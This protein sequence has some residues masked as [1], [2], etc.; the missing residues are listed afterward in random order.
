MVRVFPM[1]P[2]VQCFA[3]LVA[4]VK[5]VACCVTVASLQETSVVVVELIGR[6]CSFRLLFVVFSVPVLVPSA[7]FLFQT[8][9]LKT[10]LPLINFCKLSSLAHLRS[11][12]SR[13]SWSPWLSFVFLQQSSFRYRP[14]PYYSD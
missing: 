11:V 9:T 2:S 3:A 5:P 1:L 14:L 10:Q 7:Y 4:S 8:L 12:S 13:Y 6:W